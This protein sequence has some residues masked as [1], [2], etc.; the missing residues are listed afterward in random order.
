MTKPRT[1]YR[2]QQ[3]AD[4]VSACPEIS[5]AGALRGRPAGPETRYMRPLDRAIAP[6]DLGRAVRGRTRDTTVR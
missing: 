4:V 3:I 1:G 6:A 5:K 2:M